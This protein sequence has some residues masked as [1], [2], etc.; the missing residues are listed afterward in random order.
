MA[1]RYLLFELLLNIYQKAPT[2]QVHPPR[3]SICRRSNRHQADFLQTPKLALTGS[4]RLRRRCPAEL[5]ASILSFPQNSNSSIHI[6]RAVLLGGL[7]QVAAAAVPSRAAGID[8][9]LSTKQ[10]QLR[11]HFRAVL[12][13]GLRL[14]GLRRRRLGGGGGGSR[15]RRRTRIRY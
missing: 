10:Q 14:G 8:I 6:F 11:P 1:S 15:R 9:I 5:P 3:R 13:G 12:L 2:R 7:R 4:A